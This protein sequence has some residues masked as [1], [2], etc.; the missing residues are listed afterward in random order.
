MKASVVLPVYNS[1]RY[2]EEAIESI[3]HQTFKDFEFI[4]IDDGSFDRTTEIIRSYEDSRIKLYTNPKNMGIV[5]SLNKGFSLAKGEYILRMD[6]D[7]LS[8]LDRFE[9]QISFLDQN[10]EIGVIGGKVKTFTDNSRKVRFWN[11]PEYHQ[12]ILVHMMFANPFC[13]PAVAIRWTAI[14]DLQPIYREKAVNCEDYDLWQRLSSTT[15]FANLD[16]CVLKY[17]LRDDSLSRGNQL[18]TNEHFFEIRSSYWERL[19]IDKNIRDQLTIN[20]DVV[21]LFSYLRKERLADKISIT[22]IT[23]FIRLVYSVSKCRRIR[24][25]IEA[26]KLFRHKILFSLA[27]TLETKIE[28]VIRGIN[29]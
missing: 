14:K 8:F 23:S 18:L 28:K 26:I 6:S 11:Y 27:K 16:L 1:E 9:N 22:Y 20:G 12:D 29:V 24:L 21:P 7:D 19:N 10:P 25:T 5:K 15:Q 2:I 13:H 4:I 17:R 3:L